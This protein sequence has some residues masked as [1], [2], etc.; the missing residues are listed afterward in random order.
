MI[1]EWG[2]GSYWLAGSRY[3]CAVRPTLSAM[4]VKMKWWTDLVELELVMTTS[5]TSI[6]ARPSLRTRRIP[7]L[8]LFTLC[9]T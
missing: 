4:E 3:H 1:L 9:I 2:G 5:T 6:P 7:D 8:G